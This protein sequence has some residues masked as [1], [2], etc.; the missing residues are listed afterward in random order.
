M[1]G[2]W[3]TTKQRA[4]A[5]TVCGRIRARRA[6]R[7]EDVTLRRVSAELWRSELRRRQAEEEYAGSPFLPGVDVVEHDAQRFVVEL[8]RSWAG[9]AADRA[10]RTVVGDRR[11]PRQA[12]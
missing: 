6:P 8:H 12:V 7:R 5:L 1:R 9:A 3:S 4:H 10:S 11:L 2:R